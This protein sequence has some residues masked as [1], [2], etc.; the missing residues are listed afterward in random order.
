AG[1]NY[2]GVT[3]T[4]SGNLPLVQDVAETIQLSPLAQG[5]PY[6]VYFVIETL[7]GDQ[8]VFSDVVSDSFTTLLPPPA[9]VTVVPGDEEVTVS[10]SAVM[11]ADEY[12]VAGDPDGSCVISAPATSCVID[13]LTNDVSYTFTV[14]ARNASVSSEPSA[15]SSAV[16]PGAMPALPV[17]VF[18]P[19]AFW[20]MVLSAFLLGVFRL[21]TAAT[22]TSS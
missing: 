20:V 6:T 18:G 16:L 22:N 4:T 21:R 13:G 15:P 12:E 14:V 5:T 9:S 19:W 11:N 3:V 2:G 17:P 10:W 7:D 1:V 8:P